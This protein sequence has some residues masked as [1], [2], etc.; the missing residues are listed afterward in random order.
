MLNFS[1]EVLLQ[2]AKPIQVE[3]IIGNINKNDKVLQLEKIGDY[4]VV[5]KIGTVNF[6]V[7]LRV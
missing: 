5:K 7:Y 6:N 3:R 2:T 4:F 1:T